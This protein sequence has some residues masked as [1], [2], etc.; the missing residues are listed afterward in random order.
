LKNDKKIT[1]V[2]NVTKVTRITSSSAIA[3]RQCCRWASFGKKKTK[4]WK[5]IFCRQ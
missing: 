3:E 2:E 1:K 5:T 4:K